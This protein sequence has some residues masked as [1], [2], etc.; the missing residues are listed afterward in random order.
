M[1]EERCVI[2]NAIIP[3][4]RQVC[5]ECEDKYGRDPSRTK[6]LLRVFRDMEW[7]A[8]HAAD[9]IRQAEEMMTSM[10][11]FSSSTPVQGGGNKREEMLIN[12]IDRKA[13]AEYAV[14]YMEMMTRALD[15]LTNDEKDL[16]IS[17]FADRI[18]IRW[19]CR[20]YHVGKT[21]AYELCNN[22]LIH[23]DRL[24]F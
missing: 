20:K 21:R 15:H 23:L 7:K 18:G 10:A 14:D 17:F 6:N 19:V 1:S 24:L 2:C 22:A 4:G 3:E 8:S 13:G 11:G 5:P 12:C 16:V 9:I